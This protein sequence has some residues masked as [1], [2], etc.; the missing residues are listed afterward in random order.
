MHFIGNRAI[1]LDNGNGQIS[2]NSGYAAISFFLS[3]VVL[4]AAFYFLAV[5]STA[6]GYFLATSAFLTG[7]AV[8]GMNFVGQ[9]GVINYSCY[10]RVVNVIGAGLIAVV[11]SLVAL[12]IFFRLQE[13]RT[14]NWRKRS[15][16]GF[17]LAGAVSEMHWTS[18]I[19][20][21]Y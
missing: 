17:I 8:C 13:T 2:Y 18:T 4:S 14:N 1:K 10:Y 7:T 15:L 12:C 6:G 21:S 19:S 3:I 16:Y 5:S 9:L 11:A 20:T